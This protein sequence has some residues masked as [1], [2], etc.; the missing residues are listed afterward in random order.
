MS[1][2]ILVSASGKDA[3]R[4]ASP[5]RTS[6]KYTFEK[7]IKNGIH[8][9]KK[10]CSPTAALRLPYKLAINCHFAKV[11]CPKRGKKPKHT[12]GETRSIFRKT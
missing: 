1:L 6:C 4:E 7:A 11:N 9:I 3:Q 10:K 12:R 5:S 2:K 8:S